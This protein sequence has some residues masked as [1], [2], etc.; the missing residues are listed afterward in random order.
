MNEV[1][2]ESFLIKLNSPDVLAVSE[3]NMDDS[4][5]FGMLSWRSCHYLIQKDSVTHMHMQIRIS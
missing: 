5:Y 2:S 1:E 4:I 3:T